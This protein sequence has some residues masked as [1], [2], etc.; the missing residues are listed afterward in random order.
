VAG[1]FFGFFLGTSEVSEK[2]MPTD[3]KAQDIQSLKEAMSNC[4]IAISTDYSGL[5][6]SEMSE[7]RTALRQNGIKYKVVKNTL[8]RIAADE[9][10]IPEIKDLVDGTTAIAFGYGDEQIP[11]KVITKYIEDSGVGLGIRNSLIGSQIFT[12]DQLKQLA[13]LPGKEELAA[14]LVGQLHGHLASLVYVLNNPLGRLARTLNGPSNNL[15]NV[16]NA[17]VQ[18][19]S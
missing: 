19:G 9:A 16:L 18:Q 17:R 14:K 8:L 15:V 2:Y 10:Q 1:F 3:R 12:P 13:D 6:V 5:N 7:L 4:T 11:A